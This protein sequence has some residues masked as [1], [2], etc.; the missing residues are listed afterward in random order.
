VAVEDRGDAWLLRVEDS[1]PG[2]PTDERELALARFHRGLGHDA[3]GSGLGL[4]IVQR[5]VERHG[6][7]LQLDDSPLGGLRVQVRLPR[8]PAPALG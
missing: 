6:G 7:A 2:I 3:S 5:V 1:G 8:S 4:S